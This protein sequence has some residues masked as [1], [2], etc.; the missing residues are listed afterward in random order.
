MIWGSNAN[1][2]DSLTYQVVGQQ[3]H[4]VS[5][6]AYNAGPT[7]ACHTCCGNFIKHACHRV[8]T[9]P[10]LNKSQSVNGF[11]SSA[12]SSAIISLWA[13][14]DSILSVACYFDVTWLSLQCGDRLVSLPFVLRNRT[15]KG[16]WC[17]GQPGAKRC[18]W[19]CYTVAWGPPGQG[20]P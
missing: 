15:A 10:K 5:H 9:A 18:N 3:P 1:V 12:I 8:A 2:I 7:L 4:T 13:R 6:H 16:K 19:G 11:Y 17:Y 14:T 20:A